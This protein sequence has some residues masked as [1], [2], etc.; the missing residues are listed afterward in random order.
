MSLPTVVIAGRPNVGKSTLMNRIYGSREAIV[1]ER[2]GVTRDRK[3]VEAEWLGR[4][5]TVVDTGGWMAFLSGGEGF[6]TFNKFLQMAEAETC[7]IS[8]F[9]LTPIFEDVFDGSSIVIMCTGLR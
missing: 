1:E 7:Y 9:S 6:R 5:F 3:S 2:P 8:A 4:H